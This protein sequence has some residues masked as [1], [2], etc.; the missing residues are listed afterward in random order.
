[1]FR[2]AA[3]SGRK[4]EAPDSIPNPALLF[5]FFDSEFSIRRAKESPA[6]Q[7]N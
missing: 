4:K 7:L 1:M 5:F 2:T 6:F 3:G